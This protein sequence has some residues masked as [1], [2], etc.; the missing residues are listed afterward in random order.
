M[1]E[2]NNSEALTQELQSA[3]KTIK[4]AILQS[5]ARAAQMI[6]GEQQSLYYG[7]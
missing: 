4:T 5:Q 2:R 1:E 3:V 6:N 7:K